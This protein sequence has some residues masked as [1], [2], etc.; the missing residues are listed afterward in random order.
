MKDILAISDPPYY[1]ACPNPWACDIMKDWRNHRP[2]SND[3][4]DYLREP[5]AADV[6]EGKYDPIYK[7]HPYPTKVPHKAIMRYILH[8][9]SPGDII[10]DGFS[11]TGMTGVAAQLCGDRKVVESLGYKVDKQGRVHTRS[12]VS[13]N[14]SEWI[15]ISNLGSRRA[16][17]NDLSPAA[18][19]ITYNYNTP[20]DVIS[21]ERRMKQVLEKV[22]SECD[23]MYETIHSNG[24]VGR[25]NYTTWSDVFACGECGGEI[26][27]WNEAVDIESGKVRDSFNCPHC[28]AKMTKRS[29]DRKWETKFDKALNEP[30]SQAVQSPVLINYS[31][32]TARHQK[33]VDASDLALLQKIDDSAID[34]WF[35]TEHLPDG[36]NT[37]QPINSHGVAHVHQFYS[38]RKP[39]CVGDVLF[40]LY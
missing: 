35:P 18:S 36:Y 7:Y 25:I 29:L 22:E 28:N 34:D 10:L 1:T 32:G 12:D 37:R 14:D 4:E 2:D 39:P 33:S 13:N 21:F 24:A 15:K 6:S 30:V 31:V 8:Y 5:F 27:F 17:L 19:F 3:G 38:R 16:V 20:V 40:S 23:W 26:V 11:G 9:T